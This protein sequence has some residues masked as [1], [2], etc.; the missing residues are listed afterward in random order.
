M[1]RSEISV[2]PHKQWIIHK[3]IFYKKISLETQVGLRLFL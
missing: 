1:P 3:T 2:S